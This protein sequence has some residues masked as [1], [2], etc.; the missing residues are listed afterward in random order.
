MKFYAKPGHRLTLEEQALVTS[1]AGVTK[2]TKKQRDAL[3]AIANRWGQWPGGCKSRYQSV[4]AVAECSLFYNGEIEA[5]TLLQYFGW[6]AY[7]RPDLVS[8]HTW[9]IDIEPGKFTISID[10]QGDSDEVYSFDSRDEQKAFLEA[11][12]A[13]DPTNELHTVTE[14]TP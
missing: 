11:L 5:A 8:A 13:I 6:W 10:N 4:V 1:L 14:I 7:N 2:F 9:S 3:A 12:E